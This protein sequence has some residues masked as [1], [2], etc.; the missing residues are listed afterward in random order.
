MANKLE[1]TLSFKPLMDGL[2]RFVRG[3]EGRM[4]R[5][6]AFNMRIENG[7]RATNQLLAQAATAI[8]GAKIVQTFTSMTR[9]GVAFNTQLQQARLGIAAV[10]KQFDAKGRFKTFEDALAASAAAID[11]LKQKAKESPASFGELVQAFQGTAGA[12][13]AA[14]IPLQK[15][16]DLIV[17]MSQA[18]SGLGIRSE[19]ILQETR[20][21]I[22]GNI[23]ADAAAA[24]ILGITAADITRAKEQGQLYEF[25]AGRIASFGEAAR[26]GATSL[27]TL[28]S[29]FGDALEQRAGVA[30]EKLTAALQRMFAVLTRVVD[31]PGVVALLNGLADAAARGVEY[32]TR[33]AGVVERIGPNGAAAIAALVRQLTLLAT[34]GAAVLVPLLAI[35]GLMVGLPAVINPARMAFVFL[36]GVDL[37]DVLRDVQ[38]FSREFGTIATVK[39]A[40]WGQRFAMFGAV[41]ATAFAGW[42]IGNFINELE[43]GGMK[44]SDWTART[45]NW[46]IGWADRIG[47]A[48]ETAW[49]LLKFTFFERLTEGRQAI[50]E[51]VDF[52]AEKLNVIGAKLGFA[53]PR[54]SVQ[55]AIAEYRKELGQL[56]AERSAALNA[57]EQRLQANLAFRNDVGSDLAARG[58]A[59]VAPAAAPGMPGIEMGGG[60][61]LAKS[62]EAKARELEEIKAGLELERL[63]NQHAYDQKLVDLETY[64]ANRY[65]ILQREIAAERR[66]GE[67][68]LGRNA[69]AL[70]LAQEEA[71]QGKLR[72][73]T[74]EKE[75]QLQLSIQEREL[76]QSIAALDQQISMIEAGRYQTTEE[77]QRRILPL[78]QEENRQLGERIALLDQLIQREA[79]P[80]K[81]LELGQARDQLA[82]QQAGVQA[83]ATAAE[84]Q[85]FLGGLLQGAGGQGGFLDEL[86]TRAAAA[87]NTVKGT[88]NAALQGTAGLIENLWLRTKSWGD[89]WRGMLVGVGQ[90]FSQLVAQMIA[91]EIYRFTIGR[92]LNK[93]KL[94]DEGVTALAMKLLWGPVAL[95]KSIASGGTAAVVGTIALAAAVAAFGGFRASGGDAEAGRAYVVGDGGRPEMFVPDQAG[96]IYP[97]VASGLAALAG[98]VSGGLSA[99]SVVAAGGNGAGHGTAAAMPSI[100]VIPVESP[101]AATAIARNSRAR[102][103]IVKIIEEEFPGMRRFRAGG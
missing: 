96:R 43:V 11:L 4:E 91:E 97:T 41:L 42:Q 71:E 85:S 10:L 40:S 61:D 31:A 47:A 101:R 46:F 37:V 7:A 98:N 14:G 94:A 70:L 58:R 15:Q 23:N 19:Q 103:D 44:I 86:G 20:A 76:A 22:T 93:M 57:I 83:R 72:R 75:K 77:K 66:L 54:E 6:R 27:Q 95:L 25:L 36:A 68:A 88:L 24:K 51:F 59:G 2:D 63:E 56:D 32:I 35:R 89:A 21:L 100:T 78:L 80:S 38:M 9:S 39:L 82:G 1:V 84:P 90:Q 73:E 55:A 60:V 17:N 34:I 29:N 65:A 13:S 26:R 69:V 30:T 87:A 3:F 8:S 62:K 5:V 50:L 52:V 28:R 74:A 49:V 92:M 99:P 12:M 102:G 67:N 81:R 45:I 48:G 18:L 33:L 79:D 16:V 64:F 53:I